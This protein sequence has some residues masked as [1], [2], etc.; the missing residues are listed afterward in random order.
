[1]T[2]CAVVVTYNRK[3]LLREAL[4]ALL[5]QTTAVQH[6]LVVDNASTDGTEMMLR[7]DFPQVELV[8]LATNGGGA[9]GFHEGMRLAASRSEDWLWLLDDDTIAQPD[10]LE[11]MVATW[12]CLPE[13]FKPDLLTSVAR[14]TDGAAHPMNVPHFR[15]EDTG[16]E[17]SA[18][19]CGAISIRTATFVSLL[20]RRECVAEFGLPFA[21][22]F[23]WRDD[24]EWS[25]RVL[26]ERRGVLVV[27]SV[28]THRTKTKYGPAQGSAERFY[29]FV[30]N[31][32]W[33]HTR[34]TAWRGNEVWKLWIVFFHEIVHFLRATNERSAGIRSIARGF[35]D[36]FFKQPRR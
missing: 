16:F 12:R 7:D 15:H 4:H 27:R 6:T 28:V 34:S 9:A 21:D 2:V 1:M 10:T 23:I 19:E 3:D 26:K 36:G 5:T 32:V 14:W 11:E 30:R 13:H 18:I 25:G 22:Y 17:Y 8:R 20:V 24:I 33:M 35:R 29:Y 31:G